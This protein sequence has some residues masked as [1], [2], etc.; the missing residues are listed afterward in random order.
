VKP[1]PRKSSQ[2]QHQTDTGSSGPPIGNLDFEESRFTD[3]IIPDAALL[4][5][6]AAAQELASDVEEITI[7]GVRGEAWDEPQ[8]AISKDGERPEARRLDR[9][10]TG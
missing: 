6:I 2:R 8:T 1:R 5:E 9:I 10:Q 7:S 3:A 4:Q